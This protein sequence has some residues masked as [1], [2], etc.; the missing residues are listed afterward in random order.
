[1]HII[2]T[3]HFIHRALWQQRLL[4]QSPPSKTLLFF[5]CRE[6]SEN[7]FHDETKSILKRHVAYSREEN[8]KKQYVQELVLKEQHQVFHFINDNLKASDFICGRTEMAKAA[9]EALIQIFMNVD[10]MDRKQAI[11]KIK[12]MKRNGK[13]REEHFG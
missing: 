6:E 2:G 1:M 8:K 11:C 10:G 5:G 12:E 13:L 4:N 3:L 9:K 7:L